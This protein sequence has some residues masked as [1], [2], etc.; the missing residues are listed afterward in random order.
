MSEN[1]LCKKH[2]NQA[3]KKKIG[4]FS[5]EK[6]MFNLS[7]ACFRFDYLSCS[8]LS[9]LAYCVTRNVFDKKPFN[10]STQVVF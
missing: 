3:I 9:D 4:V 10:Q 8:N 5:L 7:G 6:L 2:F 1:V